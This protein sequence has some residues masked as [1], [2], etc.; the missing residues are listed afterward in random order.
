MKIIYKVII[1]VLLIVL[2]PVLVFIFNFRDS[3]IS[4]DISDWGSFGDYLGGILNSII[5]L[6]T[7]IATIYIALKISNIEEKRNER[8]LKFEKQK[9]LREYQESEYRRIGSELQKVW[10]AITQPQNDAKNIIYNCLLQYR[11]F[12]TT[13]THLFDF[14]EDKEIKDLKRS[15]Q[16]V[17]DLIQETRELNKDEVIKGFVSNLDAFNRKFQISLLEN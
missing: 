8:N 2:V 16:D 10:L 15:L 9:L 5:S 11:Y 17:F 12:T 3:Y 13:N 6:L 4:S 1:T 14:L 7:L